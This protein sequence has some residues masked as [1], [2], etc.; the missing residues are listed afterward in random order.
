M[1]RE[2][3]KE[4]TAEGELITPRG[5]FS[6]TTFVGASVIQFNGRIG[7]GQE[8]SE[9]SVDLVEDPCKA[10]S[11]NKLRYSDD[12]V[13]IVHTD[14]DMFN[15]PMLG[16]PGYFKF[17][18]FEF[19][20]ILESWEQT[21]DVNGGIRY[22]VRYKSP[23]QILAGAKVILKGFDEG[24][25]AGLPNLFNVSSYCNDAG[26]TWSTIR[27]AIHGGRVY[28]RGETYL[29]DVSEVPGYD[30]RFTGD[31]VD[32]LSAITTA[33]TNLG[34]QVHFELIH[35]PDPEVTWPPAIKALFAGIEGFI[36]VRATL[37]GVN[38]WN[39]ALQ[40]M[41][42]EAV[43]AFNGN[44]ETRLSYGI[45]QNFAGSSNCDRGVTRQARGIERADSDSNALLVGDNLQVV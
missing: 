41:A 20:G 42:P 28:L 40:N 1:V 43:D 37:P 10:G 39:P 25:N 9:F 36:K 14:K 38:S 32:V 4:L 8:S 31:S 45:I 18:C 34:Q 26:I 30:Y 2:A 33:A 7:W 11:S 24:G 15:P 22:T 3:C 29:I 35:V 17:G 44:I 6:Q 27:N 12:G 19:A 21:K 23:T 16:K 13:A 5:P